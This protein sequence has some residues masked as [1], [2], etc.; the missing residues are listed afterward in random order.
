MIPTR[1]R[2]LLVTWVAQTPPAQWKQWAVTQTNL[3][4]VLEPTLGAQRAWLRVLLRADEKAAIRQATTTDWDG[5]LST[6]V[7]QCPGQGI[8]LWQHQAWYQAQMQAI[9]AYIVAALD[10]PQEGRTSAWSPS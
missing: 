8:V 1:I 5:L 4:Q 2:D 3:V 6:L 7:S 9:Q 10:P